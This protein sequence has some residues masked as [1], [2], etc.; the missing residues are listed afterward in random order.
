MDVEKAFTVIIQVN[1]GNYHRLAM[2]NIKLDVGVERQKLMTKR[3]NRVDA[4]RI[5]SKKVEFQ[6]EMRSRFET[7]QELDD[8]DTKQRNNHIH[9][10]KKRVRS[11]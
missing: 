4:T 2:S 7:L 11:S 9:D 1:I 3:P 8:I 6:L 5:G 10:P